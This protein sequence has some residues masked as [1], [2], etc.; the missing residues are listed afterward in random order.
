MEEN[1]GC[2][3]GFINGVYRVVRKMIERFL[4]I[5][6]RF[7]FEVRGF[8]DFGSIFFGWEVGRFRWVV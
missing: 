4:D 7:F 8:Y 3:F 1:F 5:F 6:F 2:D